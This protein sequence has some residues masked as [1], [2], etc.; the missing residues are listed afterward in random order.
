MESGKN[1]PY[2]V[3]LIQIWN[4]EIKDCWDGCNQSCIH[5][6]F[7]WDINK[8]SFEKIYAVS[9]AEPSIPCVYCE[10]QCIIFSNYMFSVKLQF[11]W[12]AMCDKLCLMLQLYKCSMISVTVVQAQIS[13]FIRAPECQLIFP[14]SSEHQ[15]SDQKIQ[16]RKFLIYIYFG[17]TQF[18]FLK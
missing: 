10:K 8:K 5:F 3:K 9:C 1:W 15:L 7:I 13:D 16:Q 12:E 11:S 17:A 4:N 2:R 6:V 18:W 14:A